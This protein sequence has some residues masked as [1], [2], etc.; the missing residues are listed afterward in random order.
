VLLPRGFD[1]GSCF[2]ACSQVPLGSSRTTDC[3]FT[4]LD[5]EPAVC[6]SGVP[7]KGRRP[8]GLRAPI[9]AQ[10]PN[11]VGAFFAEVARLE[12]ASVPAFRLLAQEL[13]AH[14]APV[15]LIRAA[16]SA[17]SDEVRHTRAAGAFARRYGAEPVK[18]VIAELPRHRSLAAIAVENA[19]EG[20]VRETYGAL[21]A[22][23]QARTAADP[24]VAAAMG[25]IARDET[26]HAELA[27]KVAAWATP[28]LGPAARRRVAQ[29]RARAFAELRVEATR[30][31]PAAL[32]ALA[33]LP[34]PKTA[35]CLLDALESLEPS[36][37][38]GER[39]G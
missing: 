29:A 26:R 8:P 6:C 33:G 34:S 39:A 2:V 5:C 9:A 23:W 18:P 12:A 35:A 22:L 10:T 36:L 31:V 14:G 21:V 7:T 32:V 24:A 19:V 37:P 30:P 3:A 4:T 15:R 16:R 27:R 17:A 28:R 38:A 13:T 1:G 11:A 25:P 20:C